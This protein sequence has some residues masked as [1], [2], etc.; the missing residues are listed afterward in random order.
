M[1]LI[2]KHVEIIRTATPRQNSMSNKSIEMIETVLRKHYQHVRL[3]TIANIADLSALARRRPDVAVLGMKRIRF[4]VPRTDQVRTIWISDFLEQH[5][6]NFTGS[7]R[8]AMELEFHKNNAKQVL[9]EHDMSTARYFMANPGHYLGSSQLPLPF[10]LFVKPPT[11]GGG[12][13]I[14]SDSVVRDF[15]SYESKVQEI[16][17]RYGTPA[18]VEQYLQGREFSVAILQSTDPHQLHV[19]PIEIITEPNAAGDRILGS[20]IKKEDNERVIAVKDP[21]VRKQVCDLA[22]RAFEVLQ[23]RDYGRIDLRMDK[24]GKPYFLEANLLPGISNN[25][26]VSYFTRA[27]KLNLDMDYE[28]MVL[29]IVATAMQRS[30]STATPRKAIVAP[31]PLVRAMAT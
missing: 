12:K 14:G 16:S 15:K 29:T 31:A 23:G 28:T 9:H 19:M 30:G 24:A 1:S 7:K 13:G 17:Q 10:P 18:L 26:S 8:P 11:G 5:G 20:A 22:K 21:H 3:T 27:C 25:T 4:S 6:I 2:N